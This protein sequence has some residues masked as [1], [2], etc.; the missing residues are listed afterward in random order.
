MKRRA[1]VKHSLMAA[2]AT[3]VAGSSWAPAAQPASMPANA[4]ANARVDAAA[5]APSTRADR[6][7]LKYSPDFG[8]FADIA[9][10]DP[11]DQIKFAADQGFWAWEST[12]LLGRSVQD[13]ERISKAIQ[14]LEMEFGQFVGHMTFTDVTFAGRDESA[15]QEVIRQVR[16]SVDVARRMNTRYVHIVLGMSDE[17]LAWD[18]QMANA[19]DLLKRCAEIYEAEGLIMVIEPMN[20]RINHPGMFLHSVPQAYALCRGVGSPSCK[21]LYDIYHVQIEE[22]NLIPNIDL[23]WEE[24]GYFQVGDTPGRNEPTTGEINYKN[25]FQHIYDKGYDG[26]LGLEHGSSKPGKD[27]EWA[28]VEAY[29]TC[30]P[31]T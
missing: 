5:T 14:E 20:H 6:F 12:G 29:R 16:E 24:I 8:L 15:R 13:Q 18:Y 22:G 1:F 19:V 21:I 25:V 26:F 23:A 17:K 11:V 10:E 30:D 7:T 9:G 4:P 27:G 31:V 3:A 28:V 2:G